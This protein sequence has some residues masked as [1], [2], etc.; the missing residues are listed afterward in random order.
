MSNKSPNRYVNNYN[1][2]PTQALNESLIVEAIR[3]HGMWVNYLPRTSVNLDDVFG[4]SSLNEFNDS[5]Q[6]EAYMNN[7]TGFDGQRMVSKFGGIDLQDEVKFTIAKRRFEE[8]RAEHLV[9]ET[10]MNIELET[11]NRYFPDQIGRAHV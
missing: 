3:L 5:V 7:A 11:T 6:I 1:F 8:V 10:G 2:G 4:E 9:S